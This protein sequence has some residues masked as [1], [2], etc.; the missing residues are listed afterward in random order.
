MKRIIFFLFLFSFS[1]FSYSQE[2]VRGTINIKKSG[3][4]VKVI[5]DDVNYRLVA[6]DQYGNPMDSA[7]VEFQMSVTIKGIF[8]K[9]TTVGPALTYQMQKILGRCDSTS[10][11]I[12]EN[13]KAKDRN[14]TIVDMGSF[15]FLYGY[16][17]ETEE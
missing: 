12:F 8:Y 13:I 15:G 7:V 10:K 2:P 3:Q 9:E 1:L 17:H 4:L 5:F 6:I 11:I 16:S 14:G